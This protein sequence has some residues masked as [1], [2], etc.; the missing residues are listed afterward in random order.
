[1]SDRDG[2]IGID[3]S[4]R[5]LVVDPSFAAYAEK[6]NVF[7]LL[8]VGP[9]PLAQIQTTGSVARPRVTVPVSLDLKPGLMRTRTCEH[10]QLYHQS[11]PSDAAPGLGAV[12]L[13]LLPA[14]SPC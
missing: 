14:R 5:P 2:N 9:P 1:M 6:H 3:Q 13:P 4:K 12:R 11:P 8:E 7:D 10:S